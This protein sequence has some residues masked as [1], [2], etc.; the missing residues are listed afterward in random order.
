LPPTDRDGFVVVERRLA[1]RDLVVAPEPQ[2]RLAVF[3]YPDC[4]AVVLGSTQPATSID[5][6]AIVALGIDVV[7]RRSGG[8]AVFVAPGAQVWLDLFVPSTDSLFDVDVAR[9]AGFVGDLWR[10]SLADIGHP[11]AGFEVYSGPLVSSPWSRSWCF[12]GLGPG[13]V[14]LG[15]KKL[16]GLSQRR[17]RAGAWFFTMACVEA[18]PVRDASFL[19][20]D[21]DWRSGLAR[22]LAVGHA[23]LPWP[24]DAVEDRLRARLEIL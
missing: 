11:T 20:G 21:D 16:V 10:D 8:G 6:A 1:P 5:E 12:S 24:A 7:R 9:A 4:P 2:G 13:E 23:S 14:T 17:S 18:D 22:E 19:R 3:C 15:D